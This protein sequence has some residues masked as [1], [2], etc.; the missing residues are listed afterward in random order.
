M[1]EKEARLKELEDMLKNLAKNNIGDAPQNQNIVSS[2]S[3][4]I[5]FTKFSNKKS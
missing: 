5:T 4:T 2:S 3:L 1:Y